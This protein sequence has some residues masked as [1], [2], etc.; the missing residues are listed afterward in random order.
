MGKEFFIGKFCPN[1]LVSN[2]SSKQSDD[3][4]SQARWAG[5]LAWGIRHR[6]ERYDE[7]D[8]VG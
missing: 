5:V 8:L 1:R 4:A 7:L 6:D 3:L 2:S